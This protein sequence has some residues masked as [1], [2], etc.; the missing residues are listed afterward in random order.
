M[1]HSSLPE[2]GHNIKNAR[3]QLIG[4]SSPVSFDRYIFDPL[5][6]KLPNAGQQ[7]WRAEDFASDAVVLRLACTSS[8]HKLIGYAMKDDINVKVGVDNHAVMIVSLIL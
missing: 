3:Y 4:G 1:N 6:L 5:L 7:L 2:T 8:I